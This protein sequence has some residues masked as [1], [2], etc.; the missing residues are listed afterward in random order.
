[1]RSSKRL[2]FQRLVFIVNVSMRV[3][4]G[5]YWGELRPPFVTVKG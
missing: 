5:A 4:G 2:H 1:M 3:C